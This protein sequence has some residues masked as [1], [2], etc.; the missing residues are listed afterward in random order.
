MTPCPNC[1]SENTEGARFCSTCGHSL[2]TR[3]SVEERRHVTA[4]F[5]DLVA[6]TSMS[7]RL[8][9]EI[10]RGVVSQYFERAKT[11]I[12]GIGGTVEKFS[13]D[14]VM[15]VFGLPQAHEDDP[16]RAVRAAFAIRD[17]LAE[18]A[19]EAASRHGIELQVRIGIEAGEVVVGDP[20]SGA[21]M[22]TGD[23]I[24]VAAR[25]EQ[26][27]EPGEIVIGPAVHE[28]TGRAIA[29]EPAGAGRSTARPRPSTPGGHRV[30][31]RA[32]EARGIPG[33]E[34][35]LTGRDEELTILRDA[36]RR[37][38]SENKA[39][40]FTVL[41][42]PG[43]GKSRLTREL[44]QRAPD[45]WM[46]DPPRPLPPVRRGHHVLARRRDR[47]WTGWHRTRNG[48][49]RGPR[50][51]RRSQPGCRDRGC[52]GVAIG[53]STESPV[54]GE[55]MDREIACAFRRLWKKP[56]AAPV[57]LVFEDIHWAETP[58]L[59]LIEYLATWARD[60][61][62][63]IVCL[64]RP[65]LLDIRP[66]WGSGR[67]E[68]SR[69]Q[70]EPL[71]REETA[72]LVRS[73]LEVEDLPETLRQQVLDRA[74]G[75]PLFVEETVRMLIERGAVVERE[76]RWVASKSIGQIEVPD[77]IEALIRARLDTLP[78]EERSVLQAASVIGRVFQRSAVATL[79]DE[80][81]ERHL[82]QAVLRDIVTEEP[83]ADPSY[84][85]KHIV[86]RDVA[87]ATLPKARRAVLHRGWSSGSWAG[88][89]IGEPN[90]WRSRPITWSR[91]RG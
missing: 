58:L 64:A 88:R 17:G 51:R 79:V 78:R 72:T 73:L 31:V 47:A 83:A 20:F 44:E 3:V 18:L 74:E 35:P 13:G 50:P 45:R 81:V 6:S 75:N 10:V 30:A 4:L 56:P 67:M 27:A 29:C 43:V 24:N 5:A 66:A 12:R 21:T 38:R 25:L 85:F 37:A 16:E 23:A 9:P 61:P 71:T 11:E 28:V 15:A 41:G 46:A 65:E 60:R 89:G 49:R 14:A 80:P 82:E 62:L 19:P 39:M 34:A 52:A 63:L 57:A 69:I 54:S 8:D 26:H 53:L 7:D 42:L 76:G 84:R 68:A 77:S 32:R 22:A 33:H 55:A 36:A 70:L 87:Y 40:L 48:S 86:I 91:R 59:D 2:M 1:G 90:S